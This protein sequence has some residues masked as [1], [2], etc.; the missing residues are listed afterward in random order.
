MSAPPRRIIRAVEFLG[1]RG[2][3]TVLEVGCGAGHGLALMVE[4][5]K[6]GRL[7]GI[8][9]SMIQVKAA[10]VRNRAAIAAGHLR[11]EQLSLDEAVESLA[12]HFGK[13]VAVNVNAFWT[14]AEGSLSSAKRL[15]RPGGHL[16]LVYEAPSAAR[17][18]SL[19]TTLPEVL[20][21]NG[22]V[23]AR[24]ELEGTH[25]AISAKRKK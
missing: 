16:Y 22:F 12:E 7:V 25:Y 19:A 9:R 1:L 18:Q 21:A 14:G 4:R 20:N 23:A 24:T 10:R 15:L 8:D 17:A 13:V 5:V 11:I 3:D 6:R 2:T